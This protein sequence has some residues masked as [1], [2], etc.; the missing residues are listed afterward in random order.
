MKYFIA[1]LLLTVS[2]ISQ[3]QAQSKEISKVKQLYDAAKYDKCINKADTY[4]KKNKSLK[5]LHVFKALANFEKYKNLKQLKYLNAALLS[6]KKAKK[7]V[8][9]YKSSYNKKFLEIKSECK[10]TGD[11]LY[12]AKRQNVSKK[13]YKYLATI[14]KDTTEQ[15]LD[16]FVYKNHPN[17]NILKDIK[18]RKINQTDSKGRKQ[19]LWKKAYPN[20]VVAYQVTFKDNIPQGTMI[21][22]HENGNIMAELK[23][24]Q[25]K[26]YA[27]AKLFNE[28][29]KIIAKGNYNNQTKDSLWMYYRDEKAVQSENYKNGKLH[30]KMKALY[31]NGQV[32]DERNFE[33]GVETG[34]WRKYYENGNVMLEAI[35]KNGKLEGKFIRYLYNG[36]IEE[37]G[38]YQNDKKIG[39]WDYYT[40]NGK[41]HSIKYKNGEAENADQKAMEQSLRYEKEIRNRLKDPANFKNNPHEYINR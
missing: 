1:T 24:R 14:Y 4:L 22:R 32:Y 31:P 34:T 19:G 41:R 27:S 13:Y 16:L 11:S 3:T 40:E 5:E 17:K 20:G 29:G 38:Q 36:N 25:N 10:K 18:S 37:K 28:S 23:F 9:K 2:I 33:N 26:N 7:N 6:I 39:S 12:N 21:R 35:V 8:E 15:Y 30:G